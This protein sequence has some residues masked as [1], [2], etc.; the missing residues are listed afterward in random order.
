MKNSRVY[1]RAFEPEDYKTTIVW[2]RDESIW[3]L[4]GGYDITLARVTNES[5]LRMQ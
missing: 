3:S 4:M 2:R 1:F 5:G